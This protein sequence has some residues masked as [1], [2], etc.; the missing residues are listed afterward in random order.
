MQNERFASLAQDMAQQEGPL[1]AILLAIG[2]ASMCWEHVDRAG[3]F[4]SQD[5][6]AIADVLYAHLYSTTA[7]S[8]TAISSAVAAATANPGRTVIV[9]EHGPE[10][11]Q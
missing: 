1:Q 5:A 11:S 9:S 3:V 2:A 8:A 7:G 6:S 10:L 4:Q